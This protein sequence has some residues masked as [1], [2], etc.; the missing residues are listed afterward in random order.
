MML[1]T[2]LQRRAE[3]SGPPDKPADADTRSSSSSQLGILKRI[4]DVINQFLLKIEAAEQSAVSSTTLGDE[5]SKNAFSSLLPYKRGEIEAYGFTHFE[6]CSV[7]EDTVSSKRQPVAST[8]NLSCND[9]SWRASGTNNKNMAADKLDGPHA[10]AGIKTNRLRLSASDSLMIGTD[11]IDVG[12]ARAENE[13]KETKTH[14]ELI[15]GEHEHKESISRAQSV[16]ESMS[17]SNLESECA[18]NCQEM[19]DDVVNRDSE[20]ESSQELAD[21]LHVVAPS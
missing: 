14:N 11:W 20:M 4:K 1:R 12:K 21:N 13:I 3:Q 8:G 18:N 19:G 10:E 7:S 2:E 5:N 9:R 16:I 6:V 17:Y 15:K